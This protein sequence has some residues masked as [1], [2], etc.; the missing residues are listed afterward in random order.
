VELV[1]EILNGK[2][3]NVIGGRGTFHCWVSV[4]ECNKGHGSFDVFIIYLQRFFGDTLT[5][6]RDLFR[7][8]H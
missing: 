8:I 4:A 1:I 2:I 5:R 3:R 6:A 7:I